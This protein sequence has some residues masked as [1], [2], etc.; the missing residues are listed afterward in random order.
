MKWCKYSHDKLSMYSLEC[1]FGVYFPHC[2]ATW[3]INTNITL[4]WVHK[5]FATRVHTSFSISYVNVKNIAT[6][7]YQNQNIYTICDCLNDYVC[8]HSS[9]IQY[10]KM[11]YWLGHCIV[12]FFQN[13]TWW[14]WLSFVLVVPQGGHRGFVMSQQSLQW[15]AHWKLADLSRNWVDHGNS[16]KRGM[17][18]AMDY[19]K[20]ELFSTC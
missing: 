6:Y 14:I 7:L 4:S 12:S 9:N 5:Q 8:I 15:P 20:T 2:F 17:K 16:E 19:C 13:C 18:V 11:W 3:E 1:Y 10:M